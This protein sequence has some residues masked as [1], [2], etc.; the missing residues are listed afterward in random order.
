LKLLEVIRSADLRGGGVIESV[1]QR[2]RVLQQ[3][4][5]HVELATLDSPAEDPL[6]PADLEIH[7]LGPGWSGYGYTRRLAPWLQDQAGRF[8]V[9][10]V[11]GLWNYASF[12]AWRGLR[13]AGTP[14]FVFPHGM[15]DPWF[16]RTYPLKHFKKWMYWPWADYRVLRDACSVLFTCEEECRLARQS[17]WLYHCREQ[18]VGLGIAQ[19]AGNQELQKEAFFSM[20]PELRGKRLLLFLGRIHPKKGCDLLIRAFAEALDR[21]GTGA[22]RN[23]HLVIAGPDQVAWVPQL[24]VSANTLGVAARISFTGMLS[25]NVKLGALRAAEAFVLPSHQENFG[26]AVVEALACRVPTLISN[27]VNIWREIE[28]DGAGIV[29]NDDPEGVMRM[30]SRWLDLSTEQQEGFR[31]RAHQCFLN[32]FEVRASARNLIN[33][34]R[35]GAIHE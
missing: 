10:I 2:G 27:K 12:G 20:F 6:P 35:S 15:L 5:H 8:D 16:K 22:F 14:Y 17:F 18:V 1:L 30:L 24:R 32:R 23:L 34:L 9:V 19:P 3:A 13:R 29:D 33:V 26:I 4:G 28:R 7:R 21:R 31:Q 11:N 25:G